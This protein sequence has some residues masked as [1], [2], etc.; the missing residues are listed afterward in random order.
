MRKPDDFESRPPGGRVL[1]ALR[2]MYEAPSDPAYWD[3]LEAGILARLS[4]DAPGAPGTGGEW[5]SAIGD[6]ARLGLVAAA[7]ALIVGA[8]TMVQSRETEVRL[9]YEAVLETPP[10]APLQEADLA[11]GLSKRDATLKYVLPH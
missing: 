8:A 5:W 11:P 10:T 1:R 9:A 4:V 3:T 2:A 6:W 7:A